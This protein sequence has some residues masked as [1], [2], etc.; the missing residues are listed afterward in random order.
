MN[1]RIKDLPFVVDVVTDAFIRDIGAQGID[2]I[3]AYTAGV[4]V[5]AEGAGGSRTDYTLTIRGFPVN[6]FLRDGVPIY[7]APN[8]A[9]VDRVEVIRG[10]SAIVYGQTQPGGVVNIVTK[11]AT[12]GDDFG[13]FKFTVGSFET[14]G[15][16]VD[17]NQTLLDDKLAVRLFLSREDSEAARPDVTNENSVFYP[18]IKWQPFEDTTITVHYTIDD[19]ENTGLHAGLPPDTQDA[20]TGFA[21]LNRR[22]GE[23]YAGLS[24]DEQATYPAPDEL[25]NAWIA[26]PNQKFRDDP[27]DYNPTGGAGF[28][29]AYKED[30]IVKLNQNLFKN[31]DGLFQRVDLQASYARTFDRVR[32]SIPTIDSGAPQGARGAVVDASNAAGPY[33]D[34]AWTGPADGREHLGVDADTGLPIGYAALNG[35]YYALEEVVG[36]RNLAGSNGYSPGDLTAEENAGYLPLVGPNTYA[37][38]PMTFQLENLNQTYTADLVNT[39]NLGK[40]HRARILIGAEHKN[41]KYWDPS[42]K[43]DLPPIEGDSAAAKIRQR[44]RTDG[45]WTTTAWGVG[46]VVHFPNLPNWDYGFDED[47]NQAPGTVWGEGDNRR[48]RGY[49]LW[50]ADTGARR[51]AH[52]TGEQM[53]EIVADNYFGL[54]Q[55]VIS[56]SFYTTAQVDLFREKLTLLAAV[57]YSDIEKRDRRTAPNADSPGVDDWPQEYDPVVPQYGIIWNITPDLN[58]Y[59]SYAENFWYEWSR[60]V[61]EL[62]EAPPPNEAQSYEVGTKFSLFSGRVTGNFALYRS[63]FQ[64]VT[65]FDYRFNL[66]EYRPDLY[67]AQPDPDNPGETI[68]QYGLTQFDGVV[69]SQGVELILQTHPTE[70][71]EV[72]GSYAWVDTEIKEAQPWQEGEPL[73][74]VPEHNLSLWNRY[75]IGEELPQVEGLELG[76]G[77]IY[78]NATWVGRGFFQAGLEAQNYVWKTPDFVRFD[79]SIAYPFVFNGVACRAQLNVKNIFERKN[80]TTD[81]TLIPDGN[82]REFLFSVSAAF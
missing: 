26:G 19:T 8:Y 50:N 7:R 5:G 61:N 4:N 18:S 13:K 52:I 56:T 80:W 28:W 76:L 53:D 51:T 43:G 68:D 49:Y 58:L 27:W 3:L 32:G 45:A 31:G 67:P 11:Q 72:V 34:G 23:F 24:P 54:T 10:A 69:Q 55:E 81:A 42:R 25:D 41:L 60:N 65:Y 2:E 79:G 78:K 17:F 9:M 77:L 16:Q 46:G 37:W 40:E 47:F 15:S 21:R 64:N 66:T 20:E 48:L 59:A 14:Y 62:N 33:V 73:T 12:L 57:R 30:L 82:G 70:A 22:Y 1:T 6:F 63:E 71:W 44:N 39:L 35:Y 38:F 36:A 74:G 29:N 75:T